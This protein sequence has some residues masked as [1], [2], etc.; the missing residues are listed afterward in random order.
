[1]SKGKIIGGVVV[2]VIVL[3][4]IGSAAAPKNALAPTSPPVTSSAPASSVAAASNAAPSVDATASASAGTAAYGVGDRVKLGDEEYITIEKAEKGYT[5]DLVKPVAGN[6]NVSFLVAFEGINPSG[7]SYN[8]FY[9][10]VADENGFEYNF[11]VFGKDPQLA[12]GNSL[13]PGKIV[14]GWMTFEIPKT[15]KTLTL[16]YTPNL[17]G[18]PVEFV[19]KP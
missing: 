16:T 1:M 11:N 17:I 10:K 8:P 2:A 13:Q 6:V 5:S 7:A 14:R 19:Y 4:A 3:A 12:S 9:F 15:T 18:E